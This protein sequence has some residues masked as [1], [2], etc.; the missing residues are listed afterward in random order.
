MRKVLLV[1]ALFLALFSCSINGKEGEEGPT[2]KAVTVTVST[3][4][5]PQGESADVLFRVTDPDYKFNHTV[6]SSGC[7]V[8]V[9]LS[10]GKEP[11][12]FRLKDVT[13]DAVRSS[14]VAVIEDTGTSN[15]YDDEAFIAIFPTPGNSAFVKS[16]SFKVRA[17]ADPAG[18][19]NTGL[20]V[21]YVNT[22]GGVGVYSKTEYVPATMKIK[23]VGNIPGLEEVACNIRGRGNT[24]WTWPKKPYLIKME[25]RTSV[26]GFPKHKRWVLLAN[27]M[28]RTM[29]RNLVSM[30]VSSMMTNL[31]WTP[32]CRPVEL[33][34]NGKHVG[35]YLLIEQVRVDENRVNI[36]ETD[37]YLFE[38][39]FHYDNP[40]QWK[41]H[42]IPFAIKNPDEDVITQEQINYAKNYIAE[43]ANAIYGANFTDPENGY[44]KYLDVDSYID[45]WLVYEVMT[46]HE[47]GNPGSVLFHKDVNGK[48]TA[49]PCWDFDWGVLSFKTSPQAETG[50]VN[51]K[52]IW[53]ARLFEDPAF[54]TKVRNR[55]IE[56]LPQLQT[57]P[58]Y[59]EECRSLLSESA[60]LNFAMWNPADDKSQNGG[61]IINGDENMTFDAA[62]DR[63]KS[64]Y[65]K[66]LQ[67]IQAVL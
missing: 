4:V 21:V 56:L 53:Y 14:Y 20:P 19:V 64:N 36:S 23:G 49:G 66:H 29:M 60:K 40:I 12:N 15:D 17:E 44:A 7:Q 47:L 42:N 22:Q 67:V 33:V 45:Y 62:I 2:L 46:N 61:N 18:T 25:K 27:F 1:W 37:G 39:D 63:L 24:T 26:L 10:G 58:D 48:L 43:V 52:A 3:V 13:Y 35:N 38:L 55:F 59:M 50:L 8:K 57:I 51:G 32:R 11:K 31:A 41:D 30:K 6:S 5:L 54:K 16:S 34:L 28:D 9:L 65:N